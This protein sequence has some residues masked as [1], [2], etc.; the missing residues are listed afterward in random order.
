MCSR[1]ISMILVFTFLGIMPESAG[2]ADRQQP[3]GQQKEVLSATLSPVVKQKRSFLGT[4][5]KK[6]GKWFSC[7]SDGKNAQQGA[8]ALKPQKRVSLKPS[9]QYRCSDAVLQRR[10]FSTS[11]GIEGQYMPSP[12][13][14]AK[15]SF[16]D[17]SFAP[18]SPEV[19]AQEFH[20]SDAHGSHS[21]D[22]SAEMASA[23]MA[24][25]AISA[26]SE[27]SHGHGEG[28]GG[29]GCDGGFGGFG[30]GGY[31]GGFGSGGCDGGF[32]GGGDGG[33]GM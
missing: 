18:S 21:Q 2:A 10:E 3:E 11:Y 29:G 16:F 31:D 7:S 20:A 32:G 6:L 17:N 1:Q 24:Y 14:K 27:M 8:K 4:V 23:M 5:A 15:R 22:G 12:S 25:V 26:L 9:R 30:G 33:G 19:P 28:H 13:P